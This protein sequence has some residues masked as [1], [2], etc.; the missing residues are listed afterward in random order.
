MHGARLL[1]SDMES[2]PLTRERLDLHFDVKD[3]TDL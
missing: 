1:P 2:E 3:S